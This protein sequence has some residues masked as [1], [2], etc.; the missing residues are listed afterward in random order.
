LEKAE[1]EEDPRICYYCYAFPWDTVVW[2]C[3]KELSDDKRNEE[4]KKIPGI[5][6]NLK[7]LVLLNHC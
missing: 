7:G 3:R 2:E 5:R 1:V 6:P 4:W